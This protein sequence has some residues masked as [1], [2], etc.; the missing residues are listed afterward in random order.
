MKEACVGG[1]IEY[2]AQRVEQKSASPH[3]AVGYLP[4]HILP[5]AWRVTTKGDSFTWACSRPV[6][7][8]IQWRR[9][10]NSTIPTITSRNAVTTASRRLFQIS[11]AVALARGPAARARACARKP[12]RGLGSNILCHA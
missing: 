3:D 10:S 6:R 9:D 5:S 12:I 2:F 4:L 1:F 11:R 8:A 7:M